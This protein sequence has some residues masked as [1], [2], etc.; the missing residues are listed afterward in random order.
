[1]RQAFLCRCRA[2]EIAP[3]VLRGKRQPWR[4][5][6]AWIDRPDEFFTV[7]LTARKIADVQGK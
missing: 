6:K 1:M 2:S 4:Q 5:P 7:T 3:I